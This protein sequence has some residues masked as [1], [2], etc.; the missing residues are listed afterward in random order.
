V[1]FELLRHN[2]AATT[3]NFFLLR[4]LFE[5]VG[6]LAPYVT[7]HDWDYLLRVMLVE[8]PLFVDQILLEYRIHPQGTLQVNLDVV[9]QEVDQVLSGYLEAV[10]TS[11][12]VFAPGP[13][14]W[15]AY[16]DV[17]ASR[18]LEHLL[19]YPQVRAS[20]AKLSGHENPISDPQKFSLVIRA[21]E[22]H[23]QWL[24]DHQEEIARLQST[25]DTLHRRQP[26]IKRVA[27]KLFNAEKPISEPQD[28]LES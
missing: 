25:L 11:R 10:S 12:N 27:K 3:S 24:D 18:Y 2:I 19:V 17:F 13:D 1:T 23:G 28:H 9:D 6:P 15:G 16:W 22:Q 20:L 14:Q 7:C 26:F 8:E 21:L 4:S 5:Q